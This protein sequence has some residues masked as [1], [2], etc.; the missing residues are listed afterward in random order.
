MKSPMLCLISMM[1]A[2]ALAPRAM[3]SLAAAPDA[4]LLTP[5]DVVA[6]LSAALPPGSGDVGHRR[7]RVP[8]IHV[9]S[10]VP[11]VRVVSSRINR[12]C[13]CT[14]FVMRDDAQPRLLPFYVLVDGELQ[15]QGRPPAAGALSVKPR[16]APPDVVAGRPATLMLHI[17]SARITVPVV[18]LQSGHIGQSIRV[19]YPHEN[20]V[21]HAE[22]VGANLLAANSQL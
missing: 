18:A 13:G 2:L 11:K 19:R 4:R 6:A 15:V 10:A 3:A 9:G 16:S 22:V 1:F 20:N 14:E 21:I 8:E 12:N 5:A 17:G 7:I